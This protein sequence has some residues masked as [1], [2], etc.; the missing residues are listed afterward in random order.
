MLKVANAEMSANKQ[1]TRKCGLNVGTCPLTQNKITISELMNMLEVLFGSVQSVLLDSLNMWRVFVN[2]VS[3]LLSE[4][5]ENR[6]TMYTQEGL[7]RAPECLLKVITGDEVKG[8]RYD[9]ETKDITMIEAKLKGTLAEL[10][11]VHVMKCID[12]WCNAWFCCVEFKVQYF[13]WDST[14]F[15]VRAVMEKCI[16]YG[17][18]LVTPYTLL[19]VNFHVFEV[20]FYG[21][22]YSYFVSF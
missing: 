9:P 4:E 17:N 5:Q 18:Y 15:K 1:I 21:P 13:E 12:W 11:T 3:R 7:Q 16:Q 2:F 6:V 22:L 19:K 14:D 20:F 10:H 8:N